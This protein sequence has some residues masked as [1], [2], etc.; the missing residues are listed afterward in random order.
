MH[1]R[2]FIILY[3]LAVKVDA[4]TH[5][6][7]SIKKLL[8]S[9]SG[10]VEVNSVNALATEYYFYWVHSDSALKYTSLAYKQASKI[11]YK[12]GKA[13][14]LLIHAGV[15]GRLLGRPVE[16]EQYARLAIEILKDEN[17][18]KTLSMAFYYQGVGLT[19]Q[20][21]YH[22]AEEPFEKAKQLAIAAKDKFSLGW[23]EEGIGF[24]YFKGGKYWKS[25]EHLIEAQQIGKELNDS[26][27]TTL[28]LAILQEHS[29]WQVTLKKHLVIIINHFNTLCHLS[30]YGHTTKT[31][32][33]L[34]CR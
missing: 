10:H 25:F 6:I 30:G 4:Q 16:M 31:W 18:L 11:Q 26:V 32:L 22:E 2:L 3:L 13:E 7:D 19:I 20:G 29:I 21:R 12:T 24:M 34:I 5:R 9:L 17:D 15:V 14:A 33:M 8:P 23:A 27:L 1:I 28:S